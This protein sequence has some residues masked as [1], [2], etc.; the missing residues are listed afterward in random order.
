LNTALLYSAAAALVL[1]VLSIVVLRRAK[2]AERD[3]LLAREEARERERSEAALKA[4]LLRSEAAEVQVRRGRNLLDT[5][6]N[7]A[8]IGGW[9]LDLATMMPIWSR[10]TRI[11]QSMR[12][13]GPAFR[14]P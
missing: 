5:V 11:R 3:N 4:A 12:H 2:Q 8:R 1:V 6:A 7:R 9:E 14:R 10:P 13:T